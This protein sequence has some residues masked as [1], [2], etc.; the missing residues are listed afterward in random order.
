MRSCEWYLKRIMLPF[1]FFLKQAF[2]KIN[3][4]QKTRVLHWPIF[5]PW[6]NF[7]IFWRDRTPKAKKKRKAAVLKWTGFETKMFLKNRHF[8]FLCNWRYCSKHLVK[9]FNHLVRGGF[10]WVYITE[11]QW[12]NR[13]SSF[14]LKVHLYV[15]KWMTKSAGRTA[16]QGVFCLPPAASSTTTETFLFECW[17]KEGKAN[18]QLVPGSCI[19]LHVKKE[20]K[21][22]SELKITADN[23][24]F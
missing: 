5:W 24:R 19:V 21:K 10:T 12:K 23:Q 6:Y 20:R 13:I 17:A 14:E 4:C 3:I 15:C 7:Q 2:C 16:V 18:F 22:K 1:F 9:F 11:S 8:R